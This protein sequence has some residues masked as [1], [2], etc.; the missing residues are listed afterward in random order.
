MDD[1]SE[2]AVGR[3]TQPKESDCKND[4]S[5]LGPLALLAAES[6]FGSLEVGSLDTF[7]RAIK[8][9]DVLFYGC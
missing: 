7:C 9:L 4:V 3:A 1:K 6:P 5:A 8:S 2:L